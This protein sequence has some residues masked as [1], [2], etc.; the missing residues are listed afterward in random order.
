MSNI[1]IG[2][3]TRCLADLSQCLAFNNPHKGIIGKNLV[4]F[5]EMKELLTYMPFFDL[6]QDGELQNQA[7]PPTKPFSSSLAP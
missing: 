5:F 3:P 2:I 7:S 1:T 6:T 4:T